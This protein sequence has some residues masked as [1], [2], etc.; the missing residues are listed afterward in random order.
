MRFYRGS[1]CYLRTNPRANLHQKSAPPLE[2]DGGADEDPVALL[3]EHLEPV[4]ALLPPLPPL[5]PV[6][7]PLLLVLATP[8]G[9]PL[10]PLPPLPLPEPLPPLPP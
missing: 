6:A 1:N 9:P 10:P 5:P 8:A 4:P 7:F 3:A 2:S